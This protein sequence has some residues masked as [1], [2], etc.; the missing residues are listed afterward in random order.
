MA[1]E[2]WMISPKGV[3]VSF[4]LVFPTDSKVDDKTLVDIKQVFSWEEL[5]KTTPYNETIIAEFK[6][7]GISCDESSFYCWS[8]SRDGSEGDYFA[9]ERTFTGDLILY[10]IF[11]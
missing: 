8:A 1:G 4:V 9:K 11:K 5:V 10:S 2:D 6:T 3:T 7:A